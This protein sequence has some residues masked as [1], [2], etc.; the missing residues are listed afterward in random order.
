[1]LNETEQTIDRTIGDLR[2]RLGPNAVILMRT[3]YNAFLK[4]GCATPDVAA[5]GNATLEGLPGSVLDRGLNDRI[6]SVAAK[7][8]AKVVDLFLP[9]AAK[10]DTFVASDCVHPSGAGYQA[11]ATLSGAAF[12]AAP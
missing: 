3:Q 4:P 12:L 7:Y 2:Q 8:A 5:L 1:L 11:I 9:F 10:A 6:R